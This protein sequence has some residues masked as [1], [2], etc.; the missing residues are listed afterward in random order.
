MLIIN[1]R[2]DAYLI[3][4]QASAKLPDLLLRIFFQQTVTDPV[5]KEGGI[6][7]DVI[8]ISLENTKYL[9]SSANAGGIGVS[10]VQ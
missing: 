2:C 8:L 10:I 3:L 6:H 4:G 1:H 7:D 5:K 9:F